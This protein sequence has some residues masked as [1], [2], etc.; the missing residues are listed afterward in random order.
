MHM[1]SVIVHVIYSL[2]PSELNL[3]TLC[4]LCCFALLPPGVYIY[5][6]VLL[7][8][9]SLL[10]CSL[11]E[12]LSLDELQDFVNDTVFEVLAYPYVHLK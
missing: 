3:S 1:V 11:H 6:L 10:R 7:F 5:L 9:S 8:H 4:F 12:V 2:A